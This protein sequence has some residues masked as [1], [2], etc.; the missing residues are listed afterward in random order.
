MKIKFTKDEEKAYAEVTA[1]MLDL[2]GSFNVS[3]EA[4]IAL[5]DTLTP[6]EAFLIGV[7]IEA[8]RRDR[9]VLTKAL[10]ASRIDTITAELVRRKTEGRS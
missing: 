4:P 9:D 10:L 8:T 2:L 3:K 6:F 1:K 5:M 7:S